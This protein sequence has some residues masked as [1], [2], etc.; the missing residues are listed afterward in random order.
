MKKKMKIKMKIKIKINLC[1]RSSSSSFLLLQKINYKHSIEI[2]KLKKIMDGRSK[3]KKE[4][5][6]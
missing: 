1:G 2:N 6:T 3:K 5:E 4:K